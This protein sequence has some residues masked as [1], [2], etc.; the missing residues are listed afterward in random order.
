MSGLSSFIEICNIQSWL[1]GVP[2]GDFLHL[3]EWLV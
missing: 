1:L 3:E 2:D